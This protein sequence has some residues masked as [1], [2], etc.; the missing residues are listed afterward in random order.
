MAKL[1][2]LTSLEEVTYTGRFSDGSDREEH[3]TAVWEAVVLSDGERHTLR[4]EGAEPTPQ[5]IADAVP[6]PLELPPRTDG[7]K[8]ADQLL[9]EVVSKVT[10]ID[11]KVTAKP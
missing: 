5:Q 11:G 8:D 7:Q 4:F 2:S 1:L 9:A 3:R 10:S 6:I